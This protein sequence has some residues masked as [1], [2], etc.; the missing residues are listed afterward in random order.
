MQDCI[1]GAI[2]NRAERGI[3]DA[4]RYYPLITVRRPCPDRSA[5]DSCS[6]E[7]RDDASCKNNQTALSGHPQTGQHPASAMSPLRGRD[8]LPGNVGST[9]LWR[10]GQGAHTI[11]LQDLP[12]PHRRTSSG[13]SG[14]AWGLCQS[15]PASAAAR[16]RPGSAPLFATRS[17]VNSGFQWPA[18]SL[19]SS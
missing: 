17:K 12:H 16:T 4:R 5:S 11:C 3:T 1:R 18:R 2:P 9:S 19:V 10:T 13:L 8:A 15:A 14:T 7:T 6:E